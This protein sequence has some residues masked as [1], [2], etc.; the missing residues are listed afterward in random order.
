MGLNVYDYHNRTYDPAIA[1]W[2]QID[3]MAEQGRRWSPYNYAMNNPIYFIDPDGM[4]PDNPIKGLI[5]RVK[6]EVKSYVSNKVNNVVSS[7]KNYVGQKR[8]E[9]LNAITPNNPFTK[10]KPEKAEKG[11]G[12]GV[13]FTVEGGKEGA[14]TTP[15][16]DRDVQSEDMTSFMTLATDIFGPETKLP[17]VAPDGSNPLNGETKGEAATESTMSTATSSENDDMIEVKIPE[18][19]F[20]D[21]PNSK[22]ANHHFKDTTVK[23]IDSAKVVNKAKNKQSEDI[24]KFN[25]EH[26]TNF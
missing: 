24:K 1:R 9:L 6:H 11:S 19:T 22:S 3:P 18:S 2:W 5:N 17:G 7:V 14:M 13:N 23:R 12:Y 8:R 21:S 15:Q 26:G 25:K 4:W 16:G 20:D 10:T